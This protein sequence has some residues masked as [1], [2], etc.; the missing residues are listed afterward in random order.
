MRRRT[1]LLLALGVVIG[2]LVAARLAAPI[3]VER[4]VNRELAALGEYRGHV[5]EVDVFLWRGGYALRNVEIVKPAAKGETRDTPFVSMP[6]MDLRLEWPALFRGQAVG[7]A[8]MFSPVLNLVQAEG[9]EDTQLGTGVNWP[10]KIRDLFPFRLNVVQVQ[11]GLVTFRAPGIQAEESLTMRDFQLLLRNLT[12]VSRVE[13]AAFADILLTGRIMGN[14]P[15]KLEGRID[16]NEELPTFDID[17]G[18]ENARLVDV[19]PWLR[20]FLKVDAQDGVFSMYSELAA[21]NGRFEGYVKPILENPKIFDHKEEVG[22]PFQ[23]AWEALVGLAAKIF[24]N[25]QEEQVA[26]EI[27][28]R[29][30]FE[31]PRAGLLTAFVN[32]VRNAF[33][34]A[35]THALE[36]SISLRDV[37]Q[38]TACVSADGEIEC[39]QEQIENERDKPQNDRERRRQRRKD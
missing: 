34:G 13:E 35:F 12:N 37:G 36:G 1:K 18:L 23:K 8:V 31:E 15:V 19:N 17:L 5:A 32:L 14:A 30:E 33:V 38:D 7:E 3:A 4:Y 27:P 24:E 11:N 39:N 25:R 21:A 29:G 20:R 16:P 10:Q 22:G 9:D 2:V 28:L 6:Q 26:T